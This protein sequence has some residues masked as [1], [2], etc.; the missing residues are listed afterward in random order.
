M[1]SSPFDVENSD[2]NSSDSYLSN[3]SSSKTIQNLKN[4]NIINN[5][6][7]RQVFK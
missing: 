4:N 7:N 1:A 2:E 6:Y 5:V 3:F